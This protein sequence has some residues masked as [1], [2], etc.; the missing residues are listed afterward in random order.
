LFYLVQIWDLRTGGIFET[1]KY[2]HAVT[3]LQFDS[4]KIISAAGENGVKVRKSARKNGRNGQF[5]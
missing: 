4:R 5:D 3:A 1:I 2:D